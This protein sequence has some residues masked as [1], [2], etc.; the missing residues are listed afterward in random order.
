[1][2]TN[3]NVTPLAAVAESV[4]R[5]AILLCLLGVL[6]FSLSLPASKLA[7]PLGGVFVGAGRAVVAGVLSWV[8]LVHLRVPKPTPALRRRLWVVSAGVVFGFPILSTIAIRSVPAFHAVVVVGVA[9]ICTAIAV[10][11]RRRRHPGTLFWATALVGAAVV[12]VYGWYAGG[13]FAAAD[14]LLLLG[15][16]LAGMGYAE[17]ADLA[18]EWGGVRV[19]ALA[20]VQ[21]L[22]LTA[23]LTATTV[24]VHGFPV[25]APVAWVGFAYVSV[26]SMFVAFMAWYAGLASG[27]T[28]RLSQLQLVQP[29]LGVGWSALLLGE[30]FGPLTLVTAVI[31]IACAV[32]LS[33]N[34]AHEPLALGSSDGEDTTRDGFRGAASVRSQ[35]GDAVRYSM[36][37]PCMRRKESLSQ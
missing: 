12:C 29:V 3:D 10:T 30:S 17:G 13:G 2:N 28:A 25:V 4:P 20:L 7:S 1:M 35:R 31:V 14:L 11:L 33:R 26:V 23:L 19:I 6:G 9:P 16:A 37:S 21:S 34:P 18:R 15:A 36:G 27:D 5:K 32:V 8:L 24:V 22:P